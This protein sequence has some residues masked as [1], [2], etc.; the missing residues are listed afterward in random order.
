[1]FLEFAITLAAAVVVSGV[2]AV[3]LSPMMSSRFVHPQG[4]QG[5]LTRH[6]NRVFEAVRRAVCLGCSTGRWRCNGQLSSAAL[7]VMIAALPLYTFSRQELAPVEDQSHI[8]FFLEAAPDSTL[9][10]TDRE[11]RTVVK[12]MTSFPEA[13]FMWSLT[14]SW[15]GFGGMV[16]KDWHERA[17]STEAMYGEVYGGV[18]QAP[19]L[20]VFPR[21]DPPLPTPGQYDVELMLAND[22]RRSRCSETVASG[23]RRGLAERQVPVRG[24]GSQNRLAAGEGRA[25]SRASR[26]SRA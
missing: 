3:T 26:G 7:L 25:R 24:H 18:S 14:S 13:K 8:S 19:G 5:W 23:G 6:V 10:A 11:A 1:M 15:G 20:R 21:L 9:E 4:K 16:T 12:A 2:V 22:V 17:R